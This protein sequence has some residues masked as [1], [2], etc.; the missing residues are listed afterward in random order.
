ML[1][2][3][4][5]KAREFIRKGQVGA[6]IDYLLE[7]IR[8]TSTLY[9]DLMLLRAALSQLEQN[10]SKG[11]ISEENYKLERN[12]IIDACL[13]FI[14]DLQEE[15]L[16]E[17]EGNITLLHDW[18]RFTCNRSM[19]NNAFQKIKRSQLPIYFFYLYGLDRHAHKALVDRFVY[20]LRGQLR[21]HLSNST[22]AR[23]KVKEA[24]FSINLNTDIEEY[25]IEILASL[26][27]AFGVFPDQYEPLLESNLRDL[28]QN[29]QQLVDWGPEDCV[30]IYM[31]ILDIDWDSEITPEVV[32]WLIEDFCT[33]CLTAE[34]PTFYFFFG[35]EFEEED[36]DIKEEIES[37]IRAGKRIHILP[38]LNMVEKIDLKRWF[39]NYR[40]FMPEKQ[41]RDALQAQYFGEKNQVYMEEVIIHLNRIIDEINRDPIRN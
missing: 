30:C 8:D 4:K 10:Y 36:S 40:K 16:A 32:K 39:N 11:I 29:S 38:E 25:K 37:I 24:S 20:D 9:N 34:S 3:I 22:T 15:D 18:H 7:N 21:S 35:I 31:T 13:N 2:Q 5:N 19:Q 33:D 14:T 26:F 1:K 6:A 27:E 12:Q 23:R 17:K 41:Y 28:L